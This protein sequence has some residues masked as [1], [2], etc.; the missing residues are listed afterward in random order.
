MLLHKC[1]VELTGTQ[2]SVIKV[3]IHWKWGWESIVNN[4]RGH[5]ISWHYCY[6]LHNHTADQPF[7]GKE[8]WVL[9]LLFFF[10]FNHI[11][12]LAVNKVWLWRG[13]RIRKPFLYLNQC[14]PKMM[15]KSSWASIHYHRW[16]GLKNRNL[17]FPVLKTE[18][19]N[20][21]VPANL[22]SDKSFFPG[23]QRTI[24]SL[25]LPMAETR[26]WGQLSYLLLK[27]H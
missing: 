3:F 24:F 7:S 20:I 21:K 27:G 2:A 15:S 11:I 13:K 22:M 23:L 25:F 9:L 26:D 19:S 6:S 16:G 12:Y 1:L 8:H 18:K 10:T 4:W 5:I 14:C 17:F